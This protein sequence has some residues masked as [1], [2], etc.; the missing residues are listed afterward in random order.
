VWSVTNSPVEA[1]VLRLTRRLAV[2]ARADHAPQI[3][4]RPGGG[5][6]RDAIFDRRHQLRHR[7]AAVQADALALAST[8]VGRNRHVD[9]SGKRLQHLPQLGRASVA[10]NG[11]I[12]TGEHGRHPPSLIAQPGMSDRVHPAVHAVQSSCANPPSNAGLSQSG[13]DQLGERHDAVLA[14]GDDCD[15]G[16]DRGAFQSHTDYK[17][18]GSH[19][20]PPA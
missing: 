20:R 13:L 5:G 7:A 10:E 1:Q 9:P 6:H 17:S 16:V 11:A 2:K 19:L 8:E 12:A 14:P 4:E 3:G 18:P 15:R